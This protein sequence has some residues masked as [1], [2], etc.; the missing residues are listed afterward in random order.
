MKSWFLKLLN[1]KKPAFWIIL[2]AVLGVTVLILCFAANPLHREPDL[3]FLNYKNAVPLIAQND[4]APTATLVGE[5]WTSVRPGVADAKAL[6]QFLESA[7]WSQRSAP[8]PANEP[9][10]GYIEFEIEENYTITVYAYPRLAVV[11]YGDEIR[12]Y[13]IG[14]GDYDAALVAFLPAPSTEPDRLPEQS[15]QPGQTLEASPAPVFSS[16]VASSGMV[17]GGNLVYISGDNVHALPL[18]GEGESAALLPLSTLQRLLPELNEELSWSLFENFYLDGKRLVMDFVSLDQPVSCFVS[19]DLT[20]GSAQLLCTTAKTD[21][22]TLLD[23]RLYYLE[24]VSGLENADAQIFRVLDLQT[25]EDR[26]ICPQVTAFGAAGGAIR[27]VSY[28]EKS[29]RVYQYDPASGSA[30]M[31]GSI[32]ASLGTH[33]VFAFTADYITMGRFG[34]DVWND[35]Y[36]AD[37]A[38]KL[39][40]YSLADG[41]T[42]EYSFGSEIQ[43]LVV[44]E[45]YAFIQ[46]YNLIQGSG[47]PDKTAGLYRIDLSSGEKDWHQ[48]P[49]LGGLYTYTDEIG[50]FWEYNDS[51]FAFGTLY[52]YDV[53]SG[54]E[55]LIG[56]LK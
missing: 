43:E 29:Y 2:A 18:S 39:I 7:N 48:K 14:A 31:L 52:L 40:V 26:V 41:E 23:G 27:Y 33:C 56:D 6:A 15:P 45:R 9:T 42:A 5:G 46:A 24:H 13:R 47:Y 20:D 44:C 37:K 50:L 28:A 3:S 25:G 30:A 34:A 49:F 19:Y 21:V 51:Y 53:I 36:S 16:G 35:A 38:K 1:Y 12:Y 11:Q 17:Y 4:T 54:E 32:P 55:T 22:W 8:A 10:H